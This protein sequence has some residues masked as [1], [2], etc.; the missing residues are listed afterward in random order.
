MGGYGAL[1]LAATLLRDRVS[2]VATVSAALWTAPGDSAPG[3]FGVVRDVRAHPHDVFALRPV[4]RA[5]QARA[6]STR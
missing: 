3:A 5:R 6:A 2:A 4:L 1:L